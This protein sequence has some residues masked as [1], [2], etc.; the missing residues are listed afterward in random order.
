MNR[1]VARF[2][3]KLRHL[4]VTRHTDKGFQRELDAHIA[5]LEQDYLEQGHPVAEAR[6]RA[7][8][9][10]GGVEPIRQA[11]RDARSFLWLSQAGQDVRH[12]IR[13]MRRAPGFTTAAVLTLALGIGANTAVF[14]VLNAILLRSLDYSDPNR[15]VLV[16]KE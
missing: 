11:Q 10:V 12:A 7:R 14:S 16:K 2:L 8:I 1:H 6:R 15:I 4:L 3:A 13:A 9:A 5:F